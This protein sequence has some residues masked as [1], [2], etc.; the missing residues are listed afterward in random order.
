MKNKKST[1]AH[2]RNYF[3]KFASCKRA[4][5]PITILVFGVFAICALALISFYTANVKVSNSFTGIG[6]M[7]KMNSKINEYTFYKSKGFS[8]EQIGGFLIEEG[9][10]LQGKSLVINE[11]E[12][13]FQ[14]AFSLDSEDWLKEKLLFSAEF[15]K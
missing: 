12:T 2:T 15:F 10:Y 3:N 13:D 6:L 5:I 8:E 1:C 7:E 11:T 14:F 4:D 9:F